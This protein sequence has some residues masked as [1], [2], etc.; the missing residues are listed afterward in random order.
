M[1][2]SLQ[3]LSCHLQSAVDLENNVR[4]C[5]DTIIVARQCLNDVNKLIIDHNSASNNIAVIADFVSSL[6]AVTVSNIFGVAVA[7]SPSA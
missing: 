2:S 7:I 6:H 3:A 1:A 5:Y 4:Q